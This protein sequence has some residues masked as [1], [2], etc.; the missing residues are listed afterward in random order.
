[1]KLGLRR[2]HAVFVLAFVWLTAADL[3]YG[4]PRIADL[5]AGFRNPP[6]SARPWIF[7]FWLNGNITSN[8]I[9][10][11]LEAMQRVGIGGVVIMEVDQGAP[12]GPV[13]FGSPA[14]LDLFKHMCGE[15][16]RLGLQV[17]MNNDAGWCGSGGPWI[18]PELSMQKVVW[19]ETIVRGPSAFRGALPQPKTATNYY[20]DVAVFA[21]PTPEAE[22]LKMADAS[23]RVTASVMDD[24]FDPKNLLDDDPKTFIT[25][26]RPGYGKPQFV[27]VQFPEPFRARRLKLSMPGLSAHKICQG[28]LEISDE[29]ETFKTIREFVANGSAISLN[30]NEVAARFFRVEFSKAE[31]YLDQINLADIELSPEF[32]MDDIEAK[33][34]FVANKEN[35]AKT[36]PAPAWGYNAFNPD[37]IL[38]ISS[39][40]GKDGQLAW[41]VPDGTWTILRFGHASTGEDNQPAPESGRGLE[42][43][44]LSKAAARAAFSG[45]IG[46][47]VKAVGPLAGKTFVA[48]HVDS[49]EVGSQNW[50]PKFREEFDRL[51]GY[52]PLPFLP[53]MT[54]RVLGSLEISERFLW[55][56]RQTVSDLIVENYA[57]ELRRLSHRHG[58]HLTMEAYDLNPSDDLSFAG[59]VDQP[60][61]EFWTWPAYGV[62]YSCIEMASAAHVYGKPIVSAEAFTATDAE[63]SVAHPFAVKVFGDRAFCQGINRFVLHR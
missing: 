3:V 31:W 35:D 10:A 39:H 33:A 6:P 18:P 40:M 11:D 25:L 9:T 63:K 34:L 61:A 48:T 52:G 42:C 21:L 58:M 20:R 38:N 43:D 8:G 5:E 24:K 44:K 4:A 12:K 27:Q 32:R 46:R 2:F 60:M 16:K 1:M 47:L 30:F 45:L 13:A 28:A 55:D 15:A 54:G 41:R 23:P 22:A 36:N 53:V 50:T 51:R 57:G 49:W 62:A 37:H 59:R 7:W 17:N 14:W 29:G 56:L 19:S 26:P